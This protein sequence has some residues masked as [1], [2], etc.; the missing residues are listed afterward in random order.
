MFIVINYSIVSIII[1]V[2]KCENGDVRLYGTEYSRVGK[3]AVCLN[4]TWSKVCSSVNRTSLASVTCWQL[5]Y[6]YYGKIELIVSY[7]V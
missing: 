1:Y 4:G 7:Q 2:E 3:L 6:S 5:G